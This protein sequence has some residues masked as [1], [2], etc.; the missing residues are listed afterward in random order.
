M[1]TKA[2]APLPMLHRCLAIGKWSSRLRFR[3]PRRS[4]QVMRP[5]RRWSSRPAGTRL[6][7]EAQ[8]EQRASLEGSGSA[9]DLI[10]ETTPCS[11]SMSRPVMSETTR[12]VTRFATR[13]APGSRTCSGIEALALASQ[14]RPSQAAIIDTS[15]HPLNG[16]G[17]PGPGPLPRSQARA[18]AFPS[19]PSPTPKSRI[20]TSDPS[21]CRPSGPR[22]AKWAS[23]TVAPVG[24]C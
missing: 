10:D 21:I 19:C 5:R 2:V 3:R 17:L 9:V 16:G 11:D 8:L 20:Q 12:V 14:R 1:P 4:S 6:R 15:A 13:T 22:C 7:G 18:Q 23:K 24:S